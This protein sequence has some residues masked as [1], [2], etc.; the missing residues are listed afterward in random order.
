[1]THLSGQVTNEAG[2]VVEVKNSS[3]GDGAK[4]SRLHSNIQLESLMTIIWKTFCK[5]E[6]DEKLDNYWRVKFSAPISQDGPCNVFALEVDRIRENEFTIKFSLSSDKDS[7]I[8][9]FIDKTVTKKLINN[10]ID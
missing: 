7:K 5:S 9:A 4:K 2:K 8:D 3:V 1:M 10:K 6:F